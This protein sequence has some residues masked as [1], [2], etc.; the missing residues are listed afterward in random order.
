MNRSAARP[1]ELQENGS[2][3]GRRSFGHDLVAFYHKQY[4]G[5]TRGELA[6][7]D[8]SLYQ[9]LRKKGL[10]ESVPLKREEV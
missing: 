5:L 6:K 3:T 10:L 9:T 8:P 7:Q 1:P 4:E 2:L